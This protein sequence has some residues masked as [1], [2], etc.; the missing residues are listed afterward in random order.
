MKRILTLLLSILLL[1][2]CSPQTN[3]ADD[4]SYPNAPSYPNQPSYPNGPT[5]SDP[6]TQS[7]LPQPGDDSLAQ[8]KVF[9]DSKELLI[10]ESYPIQIALILNGSLPTPCNQL[11]VVISPADEQKR[12]SVE[13]YSVVDP[14]VICAQVLESF[15]ANIMLGSF[16][17]GHYTVWLNGELVGEF[18]S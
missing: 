7:Y 1:G 4:P 6:A 9:L 10:M 2:A 14:D 17:A 3:P 5:P 11:R 12:I 16:P 18:D 13:V 15:E 8:G